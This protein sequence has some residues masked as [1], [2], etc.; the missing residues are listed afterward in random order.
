MAKRHVK[1]C[2]LSLIIR[3]GKSKLQMSYHLA[4]AIIN[5]STNNKCCRDSE[6]KGTPLHYWWECKLVQTLWKT[7][8]RFLR[9]L[10]IELTYDLENLL[11]GIHPEKN[12]NSKRYM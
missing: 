9:K 4:L 5:N 6:Q 3:V 10:K 11:L 7:V 8:W 12:S 2:S 1:K